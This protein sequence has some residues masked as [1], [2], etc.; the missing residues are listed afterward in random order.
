LA[1]RL[2]VRLFDGARQPL[3]GLDALITIFAGQR[4]L[5]RDFQRAPEV[6]FS[7]DKPHTLRVLAHVKHYRDSGFAPVPLTANAESALELMLLP[8]GG[9]F[10]FAQARWPKLKAEWR[11][12]L[13]PRA[14]YE[15]TLESRPVAMA[16]MLNIFAAT[17]NL[18]LL[19]QFRS[20]EWNTI[21]NDR[22]FCWADRALV[23]FL[24][25]HPKRFRRSPAASHPGATRTFK[26]TDFNEA[27]IQYSLHENAPAPAGLDGAVRVECDMDYYKDQ[28][29][30]FLL[31][32]LPNRLTGTRTNPAI[33]YMLRWMAGRRAGDAEFAPPYVVI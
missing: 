22:F 20:I 8:R 15:D 25:S 23:D 17:E 16:T 21:R 9:G 5:Y 1:A 26:Q 4:Q 11:A 24:T 12:F 18:G 2:R 10:H 7:F 13:G 27:N 3:A 33:V 14:S 19:S 6:E 31:E 29:A 28:G 32:V 30:H